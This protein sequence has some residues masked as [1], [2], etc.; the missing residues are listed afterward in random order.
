MTQRSVR[1]EG[2]IESR[3]LPAV[4]KAYDVNRWLLPQVERFSRRYKFGIGQ[5]LQDT[6][7]DLCLTLVE[8]CHARRKDRTL[9]R[10]SRLLDQLRLLLRLARDV[11]LV[12]RRQHAHVSARNEELG[13][14][15]GGWL[16][17]ARGDPPAPV[18]RAASRERGL[19]P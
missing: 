12:S 17:A 7:L 2:L 6:A 4:Q 10:A 3:L 18:T 16:R 8:A 9:H 19:K 14:M 15:I 13:R 5:R 1:V 11:G